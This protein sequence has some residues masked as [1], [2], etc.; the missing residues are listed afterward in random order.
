MSRRDLLIAKLSDQMDPDNA[1]AL[2]DEVIAEATLNA[3]P[4]G[5]DCYTPSEDVEEHAQDCNW[6]RAKEASKV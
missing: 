4:P 3:E 5:C 1:R 6:R 2:V